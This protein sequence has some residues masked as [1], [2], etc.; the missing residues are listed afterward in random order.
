[1]SEAWERAELAVGAALTVRQV[2]EVR[3]R[4]SPVADGKRPGDDDI[5]IMAVKMPRSERQAT[6]DLAKAAGGNAADVTRQ[7][8]AWWRGEPGVELL[9]PG[10]A[11]PSAPSHCPNE[12]EYIGANIVASAATLKCRAC[13]TARVRVADAAK[14][15]V[16]LDFEAVANRIFADIRAGVL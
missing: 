16:T 5:V 13:H 1:M 12:H 2:R 8:L 6:L 3:A 14:R 10:Q 4:L 11:V 15:G 9:E 7:L